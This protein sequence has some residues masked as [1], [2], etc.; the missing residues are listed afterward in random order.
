VRIYPFIASLWQWTNGEIEMP[1]SQAVASNA[2]R[3]AALASPSMDRLLPMSVVVYLVGLCP[4]S[5]YAN[6]KKGAF[7]KQRRITARRVGWLESEIRAFVQS[8]EAA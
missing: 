7:P 8:R 3:G 4:A 2:E 1:V 6:I 5:V